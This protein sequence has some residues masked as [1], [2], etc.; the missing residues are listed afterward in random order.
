MP[1][2]FVSW[3]LWEQMTFVLG[4]C[5]VVVFGFGF[6]RL[7]HTNRKIRGLEVIDEEKRARVL[8]M[9]HCGIDSWNRDGIPFGIRALQRNVEVEGIWVSTPKAPVNSRA[10]SSATLV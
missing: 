9:R 6:L 7:W 4:C 5:I 10:A 8:E 3:A 1:V 2:F